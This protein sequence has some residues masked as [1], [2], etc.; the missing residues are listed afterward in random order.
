MSRP[1]DPIFP[2]DKR[3]RESERVDAN[4]SHR[5]NGA[6]SETPRH[7]CDCCH[8]HEHQSMVTRGS[9]D[10]EL[11]RTFEEDAIYLAFGNPD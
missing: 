10:A 6:T 1:R 11:P 9:V 3:S 4:A 5:M 2:F 8:R 7:I